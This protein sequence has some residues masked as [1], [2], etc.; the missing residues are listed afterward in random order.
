MTGAVDSMTATKVSKPRARLGLTDRLLF[1]LASGVAAALFLSVGWLALAPDDPRAAV[2]LITHSQAARMVIQAAAL[3]AVT[4]A[5]ATVI[6][7]TK[8]ADAG[9]FAAA[10]GLALVSLRGDT[11]AYLLIHLGQADRSLERI[12]AGKLAVEAIIWFAVL[13]VAMLVSGLVTRWCF[14][15]RCDADRTPAKRG[16]APSG[17]GG[18]VEWSDLAVRECPILWSL[19]RRSADRPARA[20]AAARIDGLKITAVTT[21]VAM[22]LFAMLV[23]GSAPQ[24]IRHGQTCFAVFVGFYVGSWVA[25]LWFP[26]RT[27]F[28]GLLATPVAC[29]L[30]YLWTMV[31]GEV[32]GAYAHLPSVPPSSFLRVLPMTYV[33]VGALGVLSAHWTTRN[34][35]AEAPTEGQAR[36]RRARH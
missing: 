31:Q 19:G 5:I 23:S 25:R 32:S 15:A 10:L 28:W 33:A 29:V 21:F 26:V 4:A 16:S 3:T 6:I 35:A 34:R 24:W 20:M 17:P 7:G 8:L 13:V 14:G 9:V 18:W 22:C 27:A 1:V 11:A 12:L 30:G 2:S 36:Q